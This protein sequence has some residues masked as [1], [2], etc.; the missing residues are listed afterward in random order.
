M[1][2]S[3]CEYR[4]HNPRIPLNQYVSA[5]PKT[6][7]LPLK[8]ALIGPTLPASRNLYEQLT[9]NTSWFNLF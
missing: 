9:W 8:I 1:M 2:K 5:S 3:K 4:N 7:S 6:S